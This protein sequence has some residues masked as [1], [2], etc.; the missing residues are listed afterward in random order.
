MLAEAKKRVMAGLPKKMDPEAGTIALEVA[1]TLAPH[2][3]TLGA[4]A[5]SWADRVAL[6]A[7]GDPSAALDG[8]AWSLGMNDGAPKDPERRAAWVLHTAEVRDLLVFAVGDAF[9]EARARAGVTG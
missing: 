1:G 5:I 6:L 8:I 2:L 4:S 9:V 3:A 7:V